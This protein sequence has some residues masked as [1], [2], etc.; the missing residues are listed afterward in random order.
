MALYPGSWATESLGMKLGL[1]RGRMV[2]VC[3]IKLDLCEVFRESFKR[4]STIK[5][6]HACS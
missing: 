1:L 4:G 6:K 2:N 3:Y 5:V